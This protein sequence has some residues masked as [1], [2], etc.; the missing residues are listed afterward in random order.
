MQYD[1]VLDSIND[2]C[3]RAHQKY[4]THGQCDYTV[5]IRYFDCIMCDWAAQTSK[6]IIGW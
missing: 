6:L 4:K 3:S 1:G 5:Y 2:G